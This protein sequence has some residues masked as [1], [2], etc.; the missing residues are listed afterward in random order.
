MT[1]VSQVIFE[2]TPN[3]EEAVRQVWAKKGDSKGSKVI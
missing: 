1:G 3:A 2:L